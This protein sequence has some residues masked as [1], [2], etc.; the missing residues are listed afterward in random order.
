MLFVFLVTPPG[1]DAAG[2]SGGAFLG[3]SIGAIATGGIEGCHGDAEPDPATVTMLRAEAANVMKA[4]FELT[5]ASNS[6]TVA[7]VFAR[8]QDK[9]HWRD[10][11]GPVPI[12]QL[13]DRLGAHAGTL[14]LTNARVAGDFQSIREQWTIIP[15]DADATPI[16]YSVDFI[17]QSSVFDPLKGMRILHMTVTPASLAPA[18]PAGYCHLDYEHGY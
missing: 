6:A 4:Y 1:A 3:E 16:M 7:H 2:S 17:F 14:V 9:V 12:D 11:N 5:P 8:R 10:E 18:P 13:G 15:A